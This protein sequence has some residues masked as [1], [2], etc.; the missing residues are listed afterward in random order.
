MTTRPSIR[1]IEEANAEW[2]RGESKREAATID[3][4][5]AD[6]REAKKKLG[7]KTKVKILPQ[8]HYRRSACLTGYT[9]QQHA[10]RT[11]VVLH[12]SNK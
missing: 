9:I 6:L 3:S 1:T 8:R 2:W 7:G 5:I 10:G 12:E 11:A 4:L